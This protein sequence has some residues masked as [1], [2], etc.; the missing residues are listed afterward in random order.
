MVIRVGGVI[1]GAGDVHLRGG[2]KPDQLFPRIGVL[3]PPKCR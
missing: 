1:R 2:C 3:E